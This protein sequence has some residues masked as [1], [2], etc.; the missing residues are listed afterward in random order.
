MKIISFGGSWGMFDF[1]VETTSIIGVKDLNI[2]VSVETENKKSGDENYATKKNNN[3][4]EIT[5]TGIFCQILGI[6]D[7]KAKSWEL[8]DIIR[9]G[10]K[11][12]LYTSTDKLLPPMFM[13]TSAKASKIEIGPSGR[14]E[15][16]EVTITLKQCEKF[17]GG[18]TSGKKSKKKKKKKKGGG[19]PTNQPVT[20]T[21]DQWKAS[22]NQIKADADKVQKGAADASIRSKLASAGRGPRIQMTSTPRNP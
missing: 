13:G 7:V 11:G 1:Y 22:I 21:Y 14:W 12:Y 3:P 19:N 16:C 15:Y 8:M 5:M 20:M 17:G 4:V 10:E 6:D 2:S 9:R 18:G